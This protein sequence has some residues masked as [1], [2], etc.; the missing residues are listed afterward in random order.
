MGE[1]R[2]Y[3]LEEI[4]KLLKVTVRTLYRYIDDGKLKANKIG[5]RWIVAEQELKDF[6][7]GKTDNRD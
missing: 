4:S 5:G 7:E 6:I 3:T 2:I 1:I